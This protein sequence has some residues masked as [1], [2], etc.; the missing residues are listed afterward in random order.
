M[1]G[2]SQRSGPGLSLRRIMTR[3]GT[4]RPW[5]AMPAAIISRSQASCPIPLPN[6]ISQSGLRTTARAFWGGGGSHGGPHA[7]GLAAHQAPRPA[8]SR[9]GMKAPPG[10]RGHLPTPPCTHAPAGNARHGMGAGSGPCLYLSLLGAHCRPSALHHS[11]TLQTGGA[12]PAGEGRSQNWERVHPN[13][14]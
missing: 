14:P 5:S 3:W 1:L 11:S 12:A 7:C 13:Y 8:G 4:G 9:H 10:P 2:A 6:Q